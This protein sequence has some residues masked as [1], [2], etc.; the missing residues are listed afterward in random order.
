MY[1]PEPEEGQSIGNEFKGFFTDKI[2]ENNNCPTRFGEPQGTQGQSHDPSEVGEPNEV[3]RQTKPRVRFESPNLHKSCDKYEHNRD[4][5]QCEI[6][7]PRD[8][9]YEETSDDEFEDT[10]DDAQYVD[11]NH[12]ETSDDEFEEIEHTA[13][14]TVKDHGETTQVLTLQHVMV[15][16]GK[17]VTVEAG[18]S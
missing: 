11:K 5:E 18:K 10:I 15:P 8:P 16:P 4:G 3:R 1:P 7:T 9:S 12:K 6:K 17:T 13:Y 14:S 2:N